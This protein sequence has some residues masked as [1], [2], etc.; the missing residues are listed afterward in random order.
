[1]EPLKRCIIAYRSSIINRIRRLAFHFFLLFISFI[2]WLQ[3]QSLI[4]ENKD[5]LISFDNQRVTTT[6]ITP[7][8]DLFFQLK[9]KFFNFFKKLGYT[10]KVRKKFVTELFTNKKILF[11]WLHKMF[12]FFYCFNFFFYELNFMLIYFFKELYN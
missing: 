12:L 1:M 9:L 3:T 10:G 4:I 6:I 11:W 7:D 5:Q 8:Q 2:N